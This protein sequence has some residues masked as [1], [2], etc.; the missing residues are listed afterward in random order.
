MWILNLAMD[1]PMATTLDFSQD[2]MI[3]LGTLNRLVILHHNIAHKLGK[4]KYKHK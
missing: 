1:F 3:H 2:L 4:K